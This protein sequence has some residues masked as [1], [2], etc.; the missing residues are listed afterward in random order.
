MCRW[1]W[2]WQKQMEWV[3]CTF[4][5]TK[6]TTSRTKSWPEEKI[7]EVNLNLSWLRTLRLKKKIRHVGEEDRTW[8]VKVQ[9]VSLPSSSRNSRCCAWKIGILGSIG[10]NLLSFF[11]NPPSL[12]CSDPSQYRQTLSKECLI[13]SCQ[14]NAKKVF[15][16]YYLQVEIL[17][18]N[19]TGFWFCSAFYEGQGFP[20]PLKSYKLHLL[21][22]NYPV[23]L[24]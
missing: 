5:A 24:S 16:N 10:N 1:Q 3:V 15:S 6:L 13:F 9:I 11:M 14:L 23:L 2:G 19:F 7:Q 20:P 12:F 18:W 4:E 22:V 17:I 8:Q 21:P